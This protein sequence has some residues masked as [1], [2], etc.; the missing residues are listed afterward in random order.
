MRESLLVLRA[1]SNP[2]FRQDKTLTD[3]LVPDLFP[4]IVQIALQLLTAPPA[5]LT[6][7]SPEIPSLLHLILKSY[8]H[9]I[10]QNLSQHQQSPES[11]VPWGRLFFQVISL[12]IPTEVV[13]EDVEAREGCEWWKA[14]K[15]AYACLNKLFTRSVH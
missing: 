13:P 5:G 12:R 8:K 6:P 14:K 15:W 4:Q 11:I 1:L 3:S 10:A 9:T 2:S 7:A